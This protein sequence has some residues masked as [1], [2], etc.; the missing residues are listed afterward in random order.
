MSNSTNNEKKK[1][2]FTKV[3]VIFMILF[4]VV[5][6]AATA[7]L[8]YYKNEIE[9]TGSNISQNKEEQIVSE[10][11]GLSAINEKYNV[12]DIQ[13]SVV[14]EAYGDYAEEWGLSKIHINYV[15]ISG[16]KNHSI[17]NKINKK[18]KEEAEALY[19]YSF[20]KDDS[21]AYVDI[22]CYVTANFA[23]VISIQMERYISYKNDQDYDIVY[24]G[25]NYNL[26]TGDEVA[27]EK[28][29]TADANIK[30]IITQSA[31]NYYSYQYINDYD[32]LEANMDLIDYSDIERKVFLLLSKYNRGELT[33]F[34]FDASDVFLI[35]GNDFINIEMK[36]FYDQIAIY[37]RYKSYGNLYTGE[38]EK[39]TKNIPCFFDVS[40]KY[41]YEFGEIAPK[42]LASFHAYDEQENSSAVYPLYDKYIESMKLKY[43]QSQEKNVMYETNLY[44]SVYD[45]FIKL[46]IE[47][48]KYDL[49]P[50][51]YEKVR[52]EVVYKNLRDSQMYEGVYILSYGEDNIQ[53]YTGYTNTYIYYEYD[54]YSGRLL[55]ETKIVN[56]YDV[57]T[58]EFKE[59][60]RQEIY[61]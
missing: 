18:I 54:L 32:N 14:E 35:S 50:E 6:I 49:V 5:S 19:E 17:Q 21:I 10:N 23:N 52:D 1:L 15:Q 34:F 25:L 30:S 2:S 44:A 38:Y 47:E 46:S 27:F 56:H 60:E 12:N 48:M 11:F 4:F 61:Y 7:G 24:K 37:N 13:C 28:I 51:K 29:F 59:V 20:L 53:Y 58:E 43:S 8:I 26:A 42:V 3:V 55:S 39:K 41:C 45:G 33:E 16:L 31:Y 57:E 22:N 40:Y 9:Y 36:D